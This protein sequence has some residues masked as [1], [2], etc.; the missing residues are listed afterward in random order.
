MFF[1]TEKLPAYNGFLVDASSFGDRCGMYHFLLLF[2]LS[3]THFSASLDFSVLGTKMTYVEQDLRSRPIGYNLD[4]LKVIA[5]RSGLHT[6][7][8]CTAP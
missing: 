2:L 4:F 7:Y 1:Q 6:A 3:L 5:Y 8:Y